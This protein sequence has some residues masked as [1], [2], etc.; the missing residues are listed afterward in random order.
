MFSSGDRQNNS[1]ISPNRF[2]PRPLLRLKKA[3]GLD[4]NRKCGKPCYLPCSIL[5]PG[6]GGVG[7][8]QAAIQSECSGSRYDSRLAQSST[9]F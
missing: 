7:H 3:F 8:P 1:W 5:T 2:I 4:T 6:G 9:Q